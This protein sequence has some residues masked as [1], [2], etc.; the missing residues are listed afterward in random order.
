MVTCEAVFSNGS[1]EDQPHAIWLP[2]SH[3]TLLPSGLL[4][5]PHWLA[6]RKEEELLI[7]ERK[8]MPNLTALW[9]VE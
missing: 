1:K 3:T 5:I 8:R 7:A 6:K 2:K 4:E 9:I